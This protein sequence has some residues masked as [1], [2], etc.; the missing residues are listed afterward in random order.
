[1]P[2]QAKSVQLGEGDYYIL[3]EVKEYM[4]ILYPTDERLARIRLRLL[5]DAI[6]DIPMS[7]DILAALA[8]DLRPYLSTP[9]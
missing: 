5:N 1:M 9:G 7:Q 3:S 6:L 8:N 2:D 4:A